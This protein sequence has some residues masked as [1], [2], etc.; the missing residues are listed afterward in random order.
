[1]R[2]QIA[3]GA[4][5][6][7]SSDEMEVGEL[8]GSGA[9]ASVYRIKTKCDSDLKHDSDDGECKDD[10][11]YDDDLTADTTSFGDSSSQASGVREPRQLVIK[12]VTKPDSD[13]L[14]ARIAARGIMREAAILASL[15]RH[16]NVIRLC[17]VSPSLLLKNKSLQGF[18]V[19]ERVDTTLDVVLSQWRAQPKTRS[20]FW[21]RCDNQSRSAQ[22]CR[23]QQIAVGLASAV[24]FIHEHSILHRDLKPANIGI[25]GDGKVRLLD[26]GSACICTQR[27]G[28]P[29]QK[30]TRG[31]GTCRY[32]APEAG[33]SDAYGFSADVHS[34]AIVLSEILTTHKP[35]D[36]IGT[37]KELQNLILVHQRRPSLRAVASP[38]LRKLLRAS[39][40]PRP[41]ARPSMA[42]IVSQLE[43]EVESS[44]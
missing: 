2:K 9:F 26:F 12:R 22:R 4:P 34:F 28:N 17:G 30:L 44:N 19:L 6:T 25:A 42:H 11:F 33:I 23:L 39:W 31:V 16:P 40:H 43:L 35:F 3:A 32:M 36:G 38:E 13:D 37:K 41:A 8:L 21:S 20:F 27:D 10:Q 15:P 24:E 29:T 14:K 18:L 7:M 1:M 5:R